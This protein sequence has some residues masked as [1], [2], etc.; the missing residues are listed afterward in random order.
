MKFESKLLFDTDRKDLIYLP[1]MISGVVK[2]NEVPK[3][4]IQR[5]T[6]ANKA[7]VEVSNVIIPFTAWPSPD[8]KCRRSQTHYMLPETDEAQRAKLASLDKRA[9]MIGNLQITTIEG[10]KS[11]TTEP[12]GEDT[13]IADLVGSSVNAEDNIKF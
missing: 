2:L 11:S 6:Y 7:G 3:C 9:P 4:Y 13:N 1:Y 5:E 12:I 10:A 8:Q